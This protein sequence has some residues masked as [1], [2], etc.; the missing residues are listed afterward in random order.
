MKT[1]TR[2]N[3]AAPAHAC[4]EAPLWPPVEDGSAEQAAGYADLV[5]WMLWFD[6]RRVRQGHPSLIYTAAPT[7]QRESRAA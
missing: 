1:A 5:R 2:T 3:A 6:E 4:S 7:E